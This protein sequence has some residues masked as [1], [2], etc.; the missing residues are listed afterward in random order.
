MSV[1]RLVLSLAFSIPS[2]GAAQAPP[3]TQVEVGKFGGQYGEV[4]VA[5]LDEIVRYPDRYEKQMVRTQGLF[6]PGFDQTQYVLSE[7]YDK[8]LLLPVVAGREVEML[9]GRR[10]E[11]RGVVR[12]IRPKQYVMGVDLDKIEDPDL[13]VMPAPAD[14][15]PR[16]T[17]SFFSIFDAAASG[18]G[19]DEGGG[20]VLRELLDDPEATRH[21]TR[22]V[23]QFRGANLF[24]DVPDLPGHAADAFVLKEG[25]TAIWVI[26]KAAAGKGFRLDPRSEGDTRFW[27]EVEGRLEPCAGQ[28][29]FKARRVRLAKRPAPPEP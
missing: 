28:V 5:P 23:G 9:L 21:S 7:G 2:I 10:V 27:L 17:L 20:G 8:V 12:K 13:P 1:R 29:C 15:L 19:K 25:D 24:G 18:R 6:E 3:V 14:L 22:V 16:L 26:G 11:V 4:E